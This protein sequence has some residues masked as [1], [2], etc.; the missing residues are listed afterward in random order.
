MVSLSDVDVGRDT[1]ELGTVLAEMAAA[2]IGL[3]AVVLWLQGGRGVAPACPPFFILL[4]LLDFLL[5]R[6][7]LLL[8][9]CCLAV[10]V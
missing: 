10:D 4:L 6:N 7:F 9:G 2:A 8:V 3:W 5:G 1:V